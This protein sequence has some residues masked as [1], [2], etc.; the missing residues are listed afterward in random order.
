MLRELDREES[1]Q[2]ERAT[3]EQHGSWLQRKNAR[4]GEE[5][6]AVKRVYESKKNLVVVVHQSEYVVSVTIVTC[7][8]N[9]PQVLPWG[10]REVMCSPISYKDMNGTLLHQALLAV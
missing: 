5:R 8:L 4:C 1:L 7:Q 3:H 2:A 10:V 9:A 6:I